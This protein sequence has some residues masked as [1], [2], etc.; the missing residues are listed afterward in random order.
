M[1]IQRTTVNEI[2]EELRSARDRYTSAW[3]EEP[4]PLDYFIGSNEFCDLPPLTAEQRRAALSVLGDDPKL[5]FDEEKGTG[6]NIAVL[7]WGKGSGKDYITSIIQL[8]CI[9][10]IFT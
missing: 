8:Y 1:E 4:V 10:V 3:R 9:Y 2:L 5:I 7:L 6:V